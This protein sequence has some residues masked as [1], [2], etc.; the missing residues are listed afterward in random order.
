MITFAYYYDK[1]IFKNYNTENSYLNIK[2]SLGSNNIH[3][4]YNIAEIDYRK[5]R[6]IIYLDAAANFSHPDNNIIQSLEEDYQLN[7][8][9]HF[10]EIFNVYE[11]SLDAGI[12]R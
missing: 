8:K 1:D 5:W 9:T 6:H 3:A 2:Q 4:V 7:K 11:Y 12:S 10:K